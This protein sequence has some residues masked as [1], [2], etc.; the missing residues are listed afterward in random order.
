M[1]NIERSIKHILYVLE[2]DIERDIQDYKDNTLLQL[3]I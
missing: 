3:K 1:S 2:S